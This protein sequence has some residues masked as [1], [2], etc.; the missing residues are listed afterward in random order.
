MSTQ[1]SPVRANGVGEVI[2]LPQ[3]A[4]II[5]RHVKTSQPTM[6]MASIQPHF[7]RPEKKQKSLKSYRK[8]LQAIS[9]LPS[10]IKEVSRL[11]G[12]RGYIAHG[13]GPAF[14][15]DAPRIEIIGSIGLHL[16]VVDLPGLISV[17]SE[18][19]TEEDINTVHSITASYLQSSQTIILA[20]AQASNDIANQGIIKM[21]RKYDPEGQRT[22]GIITKPDL[23]NQ[24]RLFLLKNPS[25]T[26]LED[27]SSMSARS[28]LGLRF[29][30]NPAWARQDLDLDRLGADKLRRFLQQ[31]LDT[32]VERE[33][34][35]VR[36]I[37]SFLMN[38]SM[39]FYELLQAALDCNYHSIDSDFFS[40]TKGSRLRAHVQEANTKFATSM[41][42]KG[43]MRVVGPDNPPVLGGSDHD[44]NKDDS[45]DEDAQLIVSD[46]EM[47]Q[48]VREVYSNT[49]GKELPGNYNSAF[50]AEL[51]HEQSRPWFGIAEAHVYDVQDS[52]LQWT[53]QAVQRLIPEERLRREIKKILQE[54]LDRAKKNALAELDK[55]ME[56]ERRGPLTYNHYYTDNIQKS[57][58]DAQK[59]AV[60]NVVSLVAKQDRDGKL[61]ISN[62][63]EK[64]L[65]SWIE[66]SMDEQA[67]NDALTQLNAYYKVA[68]KTFVDNMARQLS[69]EELLHIGSEPEHESALRQSLL[70]L[71]TLA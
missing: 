11:M 7:T 64:S 10:T 36:N 71:H 28:A 38:L 34:P 61:H 60:R 15:Q 21:V 45:V 67:R 49:R 63:I 1:T 13:K 19:Q 65:E 8:S 37:R 4:E 70:D 41:H 54:S 32:H 30:S 53:H 66:V 2:D 58:L 17:A 33:L 44:S 9:E 29:F 40:G 5:L 56:D 43:K 48:W 3:L 39:K 18:E 26:E 16:S 25:P 46:E 50:L 52:L 35:K 68:M 24:A 27:C 57:R 22:V 62:I 59:S 55:L 42:L 12:I 20:V 51:F 31:L 6:I 69:D 14:T 23:I 47:L